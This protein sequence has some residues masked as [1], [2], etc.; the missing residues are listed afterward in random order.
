MNPENEKRSTI[1]EEIHQIIA[2][3]PEKIQ[4]EIGRGSGNCWL[5]CF[6]TRLAI[7]HLHLSRGEET[8]EINSEQ[9]QAADGKLD[10]LTEKIRGL[11]NQHGAEEDISD[12]LKDELLLELK[13]IAENL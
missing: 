2:E 11:Q 9:Y 4:D 8:G 1:I 3:S 13:A 6:N 10:A 12:E 7:L 5:A